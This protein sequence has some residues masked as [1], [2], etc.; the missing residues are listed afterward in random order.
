MVRSLSFD[1]YNLVPGETTII[2]ILPANVRVKKGQLVCELDPAQIKDRLAN[3][4][5]TARA[6]EAAYHNAKLTR[7]VAEL[8]IA[9]YTE[10]IYKQD[11]ETVL[12]ELKL[13]AL[14]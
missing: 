13:A 4:K 12:G 11:M 3:Q 7:E 14:T 1:N 2:S 8:A 10:G 5:T 6:A 9:E